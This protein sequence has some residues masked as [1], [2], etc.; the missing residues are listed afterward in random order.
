MTNPTIQSVVN[1]AT[2]R[3]SVVPGTFLPITGITDRLTGW[4]AIARTPT[5]KWEA[6]TIPGMWVEITAE[7]IEIKPHPTLGYGEC[8]Y[9][10]IR[11]PT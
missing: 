5:G 11:R 8:A 2:F 6:C 1:T 3:P 4:Y 7:S 10:A 9:V